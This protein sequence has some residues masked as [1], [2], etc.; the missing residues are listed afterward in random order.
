MPGGFQRKIPDYANFIRCRCGVLM[1]PERALCDACEDVERAKLKPLTVG[2][3]FS[4][5]SDVY[6]VPIKK[7]DPE[8]VNYDDETDL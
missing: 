8:W 7:K 2:D 6:K 1:C 4:L 3:L 5:P